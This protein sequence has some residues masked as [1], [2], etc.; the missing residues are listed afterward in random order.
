MYDDDRDS[1]E[2]TEEDKQQEMNMLNSAVSLETIIEMSPE[3]L[4]IYHGICDDLKAL[5]LNSN[6]SRVI[7][8]LN[9]SN[10]DICNTNRRI[11]PNDAS[12]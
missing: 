1:E 4:S 3:I 12:S 6:D 11:F 8:E 7:N 9:R 5:W 10:E 2:I